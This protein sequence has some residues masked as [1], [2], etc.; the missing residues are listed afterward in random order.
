MRE[1]QRRA[2]KAPD[3]PLDKSTIVSI[4]PRNC[5][6]KNITLQ[7]GRWFIAAGSFEKP[8]LLVVGPSSW[9]KDVG[10]DEPLIEIVQTSVQVGESLVRDYIVGMF[11][12]NMGESMPGL[13][14][15]PG[16]A[17]FEDVTEGKYKNLLKS[18]EQKQ[19]NYYGA[20]VKYADALWARSNGNPLAL[21]DEMRMAAKALNIQDREWMKE[22]RHV[23]L[24]PCFACGE[25]K[26]PDYPICK[27]CHSIDP[28]HPKARFIERAAGFGGFQ[29]VKKEEIKKE[30]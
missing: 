22:H 21:N 10:I 24:I 6:F 25:F 20:L 8:S 14:F 17:T 29:A 13:F 15:I 23:D 26:N 7:P 2:V 19:K 28:Q 30:Q 9:W 1:M 11:G 27:A 18:A 16:E 12:C 5:K 3:N 4:Y